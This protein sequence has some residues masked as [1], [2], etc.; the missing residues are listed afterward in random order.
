MSI[1]NHDHRR[2]SDGYSTSN[3]IISDGVVCGVLCV[4]SHLKFLE[5]E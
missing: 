1:D 4:G 2:P 3:I 5:L